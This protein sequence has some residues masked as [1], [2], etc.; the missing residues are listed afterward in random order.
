MILKANVAFGSTIFHWSLVQLSINDLR[1]L[2][3]SDAKETTLHPLHGKAVIA[4]LPHGF[5]HFGTLHSEGGRYRLSNASNL[6]FWKERKG[7]LPE[8]ARSG[9]I[10]SDKIDEAGDIF[11]DG[12]VFFYRAGTWAEPL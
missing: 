4:V 9:P 3:G 12:A 5:V 8:F 2:I 7:G 10:E 11:F 6:R 1:D